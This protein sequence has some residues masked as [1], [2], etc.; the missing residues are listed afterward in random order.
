MPSDAIA[1][2]KGLKPVAD[3]VAADDAAA[4]NRIELDN[5]ME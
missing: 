4:D 5:D 2:Y 1:F 3:N